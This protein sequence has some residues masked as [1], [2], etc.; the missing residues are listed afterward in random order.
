V[1]HLG[2]GPF[3][4]SPSVSVVHACSSGWFGSRGSLTCGVVSAT[5]AW[6]QYEPD[7]TMHGWWVPVI[8]NEE[9]R[10]ECGELEME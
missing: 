4:R 9:L 2:L 7:G 8:D 10:I 5:L 6:I 1:P 3:P